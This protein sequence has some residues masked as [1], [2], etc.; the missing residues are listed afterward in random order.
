MRNLRRLLIAALAMGSMTLV[1][2]KKKSEPAGAGPGTSPPGTTADAAGT[3]ATD[4]AAAAVPA[5]TEPIVVKEGLSTPESITYHEDLD[6]YYVANINGEPL[7]ADDNG[8]IGAYNA[9]GTPVNAKWIDG[10]AADVTLNAPKGMAIAG[11]VLYVADIDVVRKFD[12]TTGKPIGE[13][14]IP[15]ASFLNDVASADG[16]V[17]VTDTGVNA[18]FEPV[19]TDAIYRV[20]KD[21]TVTTILTD[22]T[23]GGPNGIWGGDARGMIWVVTFGSG[24]IYAIDA[25]GKK[26][27]ATKLPTGQLD[28]LIGLDSGEML[29]SSWEGSV[30]YRGKPGG[31]WKAVVENVKSP[32]DLGWDR[33]RGRVLVPLFMENSARFVTL[34][35]P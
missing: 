6:R 28:G 22:K 14:K 20:G 7:G 3:T 5:T 8:Y 26:Q 32:A 16:G 1:A 21:D 17:L 31:E 23:L 9:D 4:A 27:P 15:G 25:D 11:N 30:V 12:V 35:V 29:V 2:C 33:K 18:K 34:K 19:G 13:V 24:E 10:A